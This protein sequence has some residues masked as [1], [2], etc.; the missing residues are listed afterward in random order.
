MWSFRSSSDKKHCSSSR[1]VL[2]QLTEAFLL[3][4]G[5]K[6]IVILAT[7]SFQA[8]LWAVNLRFW[9][10]TV[11]KPEVNI[12]L[13]ALNIQVSLRFQFPLFDPVLNPGVCVWLQCLSLEDCWWWETFSFV[14]CSGSLVIES[15]IFLNFSSRFSLFSAFSWALCPSLLCQS[16]HYYSVSSYVKA[17][18]AFLLNFSFFWEP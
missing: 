14:D 4:H 18:I 13:L 12:R 9:P 3:P 8:A 15:C 1:A 2:P 10:F 17:Y 16:T 5:F 11:L 6:P 7:F